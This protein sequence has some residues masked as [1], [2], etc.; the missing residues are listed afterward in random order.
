MCIEVEKTIEWKGKPFKAYKVIFTSGNDPLN[1]DLLNFRTFTGPYS[2]TP[3]V[4]N[5]WLTAKYEPT[6]KAFIHR[7]G[8]YGFCVL[9]SKEEAEYYRIRGSILSMFCRV[10]E[11]ECRG[12]CHIGKYHTANGSRLLDAAYVEKIRFSKC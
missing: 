6:S 9:K 7:K 8:K 11:V 2:Q 1:L 10:V 4:R 3:V 5:K 12:T